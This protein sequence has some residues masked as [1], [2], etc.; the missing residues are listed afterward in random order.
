MCN[1]LFSNEITLDSNYRMI[2]KKEKIPSLYP[3]TVKR[4]KGYY[5]P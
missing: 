2:T 1:Y 5:R 3:V 4:R